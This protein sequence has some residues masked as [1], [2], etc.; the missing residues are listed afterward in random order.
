MKSRLTALFSF[1][2]SSAFLIFFIIN[3]NSDSVVKKN[4]NKPLVFGAV[5][6]VAVYSACLAFGNLKCDFKKTGK[7]VVVEKE[8]VLTDSS[9]GSLA[10]VG[11][12]RNFKFKL[13]L[14]CVD[15]SGEHI[16][17]IQIKG[18]N[19]VLYESEYCPVLGRHRR[20]GVVKDSKMPVVV[21]VKAGP[22]TSGT[23]K[24]CAEF[25]EIIES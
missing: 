25:F 5:V 22:K 21:I 1:F 17:L 20:S 15:F 7:L 2:I 13:R 23:V 19:E 16:Y 4:Q 11:V 18:G 9:A 8:L 3:Y 24:V 12:S 10:L 6:L 14:E